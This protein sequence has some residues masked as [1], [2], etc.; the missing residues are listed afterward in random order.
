[1]AG[2]QYN[3]NRNQI[4]KLCVLKP[5]E[6]MALG[7]QMKLREGRGRLCP[8]FILIAIVHHPTTINGNFVDHQDQK[9]YT[10]IYIGLL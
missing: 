9:E 5:L 3:P 6:L 10:Y 4:P 2:T 7:Q 1:M 8:Y